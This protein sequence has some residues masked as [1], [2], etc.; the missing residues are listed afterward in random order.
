M[1]SALVKVLKAK[2]S[3]HTC[4]G[5]ALGWTTVRREGGKEVGGLGEYRAD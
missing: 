2:Y 1:L 5:W 4:A 3:P